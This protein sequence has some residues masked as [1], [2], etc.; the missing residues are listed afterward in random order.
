MIELIEKAMLTAMGAVS[1]SQKKAEELISDIRQRLDL[2]EEEGRE[3]LQR[4]QDA[5]KENQAKLEEL[6]QQEVQKACQRMGLV[7]SEEFDKLKRKVSQL[8]KKLKAH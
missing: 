8:E 6:A 1:L 3:L 2:S 5:A 7:T 4:L